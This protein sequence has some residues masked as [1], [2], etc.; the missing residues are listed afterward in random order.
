MSQEYEFHVFSQR[1]GHKDVYRLRRTPTGWEGGRASIEGPCDRTGAPYL[2]KNFDQDCIS[3]PACIPAYM[4][5]IWQHAEDGF[6][7]EEV[8]IELNRLAEWVS[9]CEKGTPRDILGQ[10]GVGVSDIGIPGTE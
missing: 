9:L 2:Y 1:L 8:Q 6:T 10:R 3:Y 5:R 7:D 4:E